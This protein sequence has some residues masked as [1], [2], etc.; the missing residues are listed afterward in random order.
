MRFFNLF[1]L[2]L[3]KEEVLQ[4]DQAPV[5][6]LVSVSPALGRAFIVAISQHRISE[7]AVLGA[8]P[9]KVPR[10]LKTDRSHV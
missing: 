7:L 8:L 6:W 5:A 2:L 9:K 10:P 4:Q 1:P 3:G